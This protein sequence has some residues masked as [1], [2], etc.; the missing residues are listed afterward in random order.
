MKICS[1]YPYQG[2]NSLKN[3]ALVHFMIQFAL[4]MIRFSD[5]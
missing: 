5:I 1:N 4:L 3:Y 2:V